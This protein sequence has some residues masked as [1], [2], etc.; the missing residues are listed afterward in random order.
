[1]SRPPRTPSRLRV[2][3][4]NPGKGRLRRELKPAERERSGRE[5]VALGALTRLDMAAFGVYCSIV[6]RWAM[7]T[8]L[9]G[10][11]VPTDPQRRVLSKAA[12]RAERQMLALTAQF[13]T[14]GGRARPGRR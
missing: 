6:G 1:M 4:G 2:L 13:C 9:L 7:A 8:E 12:A 11:L 14:P 10:K 3:Q 5:L